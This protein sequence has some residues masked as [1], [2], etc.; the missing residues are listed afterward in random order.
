VAVSGAGPPPA[1][2]A[3]IRVAVRVRPEN[4]REE[5]GGYR[6]I[7]DIVD[8]RMLVFDPKE[9]EDVF[10]Y[11]GK[12]Q[13]RRDLNKRA[14]KDKKFAFDS[15]FS[16]ASTNVEVF[17]GTTKDLVETVFS[18]YNCS[19]FAYGATGSGKT[20]TM[21]GAPE[22]PGIT[23]MTLQEIY[24]KVDECKEENSCEI[25]ISYLEIYNE[26]VIDLLTP[27]GSLNIR[28]DGKAGVNIPGLSLHKPTSPEEVLGLLNYGNSNR[29]QHPTDANKESSRSHAVLQ[30]FI[31]QKDKSAGLSAEVK[32]AKL[33]MIDLAGS[34]KGA[35]TG[36]KG[37]RFR[38]GSNINKSLLALGNCI[39][40]LADGAKYIPY[41]N[42]KLTRLLKDSIG[43]NCRTVM[44]A[45]CSPS[46]QTFED[47]FNT[48]KYADRA[49][50][51]KINLKKNVVNVDFHVAQYAKIVEDLRGEITV[52]KEKIKA[53]EEENI[54][55]K[56]E[57]HVPME[58]AT[59]NGEGVDENVAESSSDDLAKMKMQLDI[60][61][62]RQHD[63]D[64]LKE[65]VRE[66]EESS[67]RQERRSSE[68]VGVAQEKREGVAQ[69]MRMGVAQE[70]DKDSEEVEAL[71]EKRR[72]LVKA[73]CDEDSMLATLEMRIHF[74][75]KAQLRN[76]LIS[77]TQTS[78]E[79]SQ[80]KSVKGIEVLTR[81]LE[82]KKER[83]A[84]ILKELSANKEALDHI[85]INRP[86]D[87]V[88]KIAQLQVSLMEREAE[89]SHLHNMIGT[90]AEELDKNEVGLTACLPILK[91]NHQ[92]LRAHD[93]ATKEDKE[94][95]DEMVGQLS[96]SRVTW[97]QN[98]HTT[99]E[100]E[101]EIANSIYR[102]VS[103]LDLP[104]LNAVTTSRPVSVEQRSL[105]GPEPET[106][107]TKP[108]NPY[109]PTRATVD[110]PEASLEFISPVVKVE[111]AVT[112]TDT[113]VEDTEE[114]KVEEEGSETDSDDVTDDELLPATP[115]VERPNSRQFVKLTEL[116]SNSSF[117]VTPSPPELTTIQDPEPSAE[118]AVK[119]F[120][121][122]PKD[123]FL[124]TP[125]RAAEESESPG[126]NKRIKLD[127]TPPAPV[128]NNH[129][130][131]AVMPATP[132]ALQVIPPSPT[133]GKYQLDQTFD[134][135]NET[136]PVSS[137]L[138]ETVTLV[139]RL[140]VQCDLGSPMGAPEILQDD[141]KAQEHSLNATFAIEGVEPME[142]DATMD[143]AKFDQEMSIIAPPMLVPPPPA[144]RSPVKAG[145]G[146]S[147][148]CP[149]RSTPSPLRQS[150]LLD[151]KESEPNNEKSI[152]TQHQTLKQPQVSSHKE[153]Q[154]PRRSP[155]NA[156][157]TFA[158]PSQKQASTRKR[159][160]TPSKQSH[161]FGATTPQPVRRA[162]VKR[163]L[164]Q[165]SQST[166]VLPRVP[167][168]PVSLRSTIQ[169]LQE[170]EETPET[171]GYMT[172]TASSK[173]KAHGGSG[174]LERNNKLKSGSNLHLAK[175]NP[176]T[177]SLVTKKGFSSMSSKIGSGF[178][179][180]KKSVSGTVLKQTNK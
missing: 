131:V 42:S 46:S 12:K 173:R 153:S 163:S 18:G 133:V 129:R 122:P 16:P 96:G 7:I 140:D 159:G 137:G 82:K 74:K 106:L 114:I 61:T 110:S 65:R 47:T 33:S 120:L 126:E 60:L 85:I 151:M 178:G 11:H 115:Q 1:V 80:V 95:F 67:E 15:V 146:I 175:E 101:L 136:P 59:E 40:A 77:I 69:E 71:V 92:M 176:S 38:E 84:N 154:P 108:D 3:N 139:A 90:M 9:E 86:E 36:S 123:N 58:V 23:F 149:E 170:P 166:S 56:N 128:W 167:P 27:T 165:Y 180:L 177:E 107:V 88:T 29:T 172:A 148:R 87:A 150:T 10:Y 99:Q 102:I 109:D 89:S 118:P 91:H 70:M 4:A 14:N 138:N 62:I 13:G 6:N 20:F 134:S 26:T 83:K 125:K 30:V 75:E 22:A 39:N 52:L 31:K 119:K 105:F 156:V 147:P 17:E 117:I 41:R 145:L 55:L 142:V 111:E 32:I 50:K 171:R 63:Y 78:L 155:R 160:P 49:K 158:P 79:K 179:R 35:V 81:K 121:A 72:A 54:L 144:C 169:R 44:I 103:R 124:G 164:S 141:V 162:T 53:L 73:L 97:A 68:Q 152:S 37:A 24:S 116:T 25:A 127:E 76:N 132:A 98:I 168:H 34:E 57:G 104:T 174:V 143:A 51:I 161:G 113:K 28:E 100:E 45:N 43:G 2:A 157:V 94:K 5:A 112:K 19:V 48:L 130:K 135:N 93:F 64:S 66:Y 8:D 21:L